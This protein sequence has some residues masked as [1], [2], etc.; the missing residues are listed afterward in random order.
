MGSSSGVPYPI[1]ATN[2]YSVSGASTPLLGS[3]TP[4]SSLFMMINGSFSFI[5]FM[6]GFPYTAWATIFLGLQLHR[7]HGDSQFCSVCA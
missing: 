4:D 3:I 1:I 5:C 6:P 7:R 2:F